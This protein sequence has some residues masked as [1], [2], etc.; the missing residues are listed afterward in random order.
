MKTID[1]LSIVG[2]IFSHV[3]L[4]CLNVQITQ[5]EIPESQLGLE[6]ERGA[7]VWFSA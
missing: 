1:R 5:K 6:S 4:N 2:K 7:I 3:R